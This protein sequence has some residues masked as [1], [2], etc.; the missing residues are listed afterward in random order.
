[1]TNLSDIFKLEYGSF[2][3]YIKDL[4]IGT[5]PLITSGSKNNGVV[6]FYN[7]K[8][9]Y[10]SVISVPRTGTI[11]H[12]FYHDY[13]CTIN[14]DCI[15]LSPRKKMKTL[16]ALYYTLIIR[17]LSV[18]YSYGRKITP[19]RL[20]KA[21]VPSKI[22]KWVKKISFPDYEKTQNAFHQKNN[23]MFDISN[24]KTFTYEELFDIK[25]GKRLTKANIKLGDTPFIA[26]TEY[27]NGYRQFIQQAPNHEGNTITVNYNGSVG[28]AFYQPIPFWASDDVN[29]LYP[30]FELTPY[31]GIFICTI[32]RQEKF[33]FSFGR[34]W[35][36]ERMKQSKIQL[37]TNSAGNPDWIFMENYIKGLPFSGHI[38]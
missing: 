16:D 34:K 36:S 7:I 9:N 30:K 6:G 5:I 35:H 1:M 2:K 32:I 38:Q 8:P 28:E 13:D 14:T 10:K 3:S 19:E 37:P 22:P 18:L 31:I 11:G 4:E 25:K 33:K 27:N 20:G 15:V 23:L 26:A 21:K 17:K 29:I 12:A 24:W